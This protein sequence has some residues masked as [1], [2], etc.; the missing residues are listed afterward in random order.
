MLLCII[1]FLDITISS[2]PVPEEERVCTKHLECQAIQLFWIR[3]TKGNALNVQLPEQ[4]LEKSHIPLQLKSLQGR[5]VR[6]THVLAVIKPHISTLHS[7][8]YCR[9]CSQSQQWL[10]IPAHVPY[11]MLP[12]MITPAPLVCIP[13]TLLSQSLHILHISMDASPLQ[14][15]VPFMSQFVLQSISQV[16]ERQQ[17]AYTGH[18]DLDMY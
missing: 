2:V 9:T 5:F 3:K 1:R 8:E 13:S 11:K 4:Y 16:P 15:Q 12:A 6:S 10:S 14:L 17:A 18:L 7:T